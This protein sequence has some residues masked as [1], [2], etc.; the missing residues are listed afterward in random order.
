MSESQKHSPQVTDTESILDSVPQDR[1]GE[2]VDRLL[3]AVP[4]RRVPAADL[5]LQ[6]V[7]TPE[8]MQLIRPALM[9]LSGKVAAPSS[10]LQPRLGTPTSNQS[11]Q[12]TS[13]T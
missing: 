12:T 13:E 5:P 11:Q 7:A 2:F 1:M 6:R 4:L 8:E 10:D 3:Q 9:S